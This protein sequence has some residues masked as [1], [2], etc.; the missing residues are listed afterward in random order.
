MVRQTEFTL[1]ARGRGFHLV[2][3]EILAHLPEL[4]T[5]GL[6][7]L[8]IKHTSAGLTLNENADFDVSTDLGAIFDRMVKDGEPYYSHTMEGKDD[9]SAHAKSTLTGNSVT[10]PITNGRL[11]MGTWQGIFLCEFRDRP[12]RRTIV[13]TVV[14]EL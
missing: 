2:T 3:D 4:P 1:L 12:H 14:G 9:M 10:I 11:N 8:F 13:A 6:L 7:H 5:A